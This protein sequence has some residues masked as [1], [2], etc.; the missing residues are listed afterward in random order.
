MKTTLNPTITF[1]VVLSSLFNGISAISA[2]GI[3]GTITDDS[4]NPVPG[5]SIYITET[6]SG[7]ISNLDGEY[8]FSLENGTY[9]LTFQSLG[10]S[11]RE[12]VVNITGD[13]I[14]HNLQLHPIQYNLREVKIY[15]GEDPAYAIMR[16]A[17]ARA[18]Y[19][20]RQAKNYEAEV[21]LKG[22]LKMNKIPKIIQKQIEVNGEKV[23]VGETYTSESLNII[24]FSAPDSFLH[25]VKA[26]RSTFPGKEENSMM[27]Y[28]NSS[29]YDS[30]KSDMI[31]S[32][33]SP[34][35]LRH[36]RFRYEGFFNDG[37]VTVN[38]IRVTPKRKSQQLVEGDLYIVE[39]LW[40]IHSLDFVHQPFWGKLRI[41]Q[42][43]RPVK[44]NVWLP[45]SHHFDV[46]AAVMGIKADFNYAGSVKY[47]SVHLNDELRG[48]GTIAQNTIQTDA[49]D[50]SNKSEEPS[51]PTKTQKQMDELLAKEELSNREMMK[52]AAL[53]EKENEQPKE[54]I[55]LELK[56]T[57]RFNIKKDSVKRD[58]LFWSNIRPIPLTT[59]EKSSFAK[60]DSLTTT[61]AVAD[62]TKKGKS[63]FFSSLGKIVSGTTFPG[64][65]AKV[66]FTYGGLV[67]PKNLGFNPVDG[68]KYGQTFGIAWKQDSVHTMNLSLMGG[69]AFSGEKA[70]GSFGWTQTYLPKKRGAITVSGYIGSVDFKK[71]LE[72]PGFLSMSSSLFFKEN[73]QRFFNTQN[74]Q[75]KN[76]IDLANGF[77]MDINVGYHQNSPLVNNT[78]FSFM[79]K[80]TDYKPNE[81]LH[82]EADETN[83][84]KQDA[85]ILKLGWEYTPRHHYYMHKGR[86]V[87]ARSNYPTFSLALE[88]GLK[89]FSSHAD[90]MLAEIG[91]Y[92][93]PE[94]SFLPVFNWST[95]AGW[96]MRNKQ[97]HFS[98]FK[99]FQSSTI[100]LLF[101]NLGNSFVLLND[102]LPST[103]QWF[104][105][106]NVTYSSP[107]LFLKNLPVLSNRL[108]NEDLHISYL[109]TPVMRHYVQTGY[110]ISRIFMAGSVGVF[111]GFSE[112]KYQH[113]GVRVAFSAF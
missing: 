50:D 35:A 72:L 64:D 3:K 65:S 92:K 39:G 16:K 53:I 87:M 107:F 52:L 74:L 30:S 102:Y 33:L 69:Y 113:W 101:S 70:Y 47:M 100:P 112:G 85:F 23:K 83:F 91:A 18:P 104:V 36:Y 48:A 106:G 54:N 49:D 110:S 68:W 108:W 75:I 13:W 14:T 81:I 60:R 31:I 29:F 32:P 10:F 84:I 27:G 66:R 98:N 51:K 46:E 38:K 82:P 73:Y 20:L 77:R 19:H 76:G 37:N 41:R 1:F 34:Q 62:S 99:H 94:F 11:R 88:Q 93:K 79:K 103:N 97:M 6:K 86:K 67:Q 63:K 57:Y 109:H 26:S 95:N 24:R 55:E 78:N 42:M 89:A 17:I 61:N 21:Y 15:S 71:Q 58:S 44:S 7:T 43:Y 5:V 25:T 9:N 2:Q 96:F 4:G 105:T 22:S 59:N 80:D 90:Y 12:F 56:R 8:E 45:I 40:N 28:I 111:A